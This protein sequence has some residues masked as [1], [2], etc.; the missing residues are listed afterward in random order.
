MYENE[1]LIFPICRNKTMKTGGDLIHTVLSS[2][3][4]LKI[5]TPAGDGTG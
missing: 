1:W 3:I 4:Q 5:V 2:Q